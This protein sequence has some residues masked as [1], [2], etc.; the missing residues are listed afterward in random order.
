MNCSYKPVFKKFMVSVVI[1][2]ESESL[3]RPFKVTGVFLFYF[4]NLAL[5]IFKRDRDMLQ[6][7]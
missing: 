5:L 7:T 6:N 3:L 4:N 1:K 2:T